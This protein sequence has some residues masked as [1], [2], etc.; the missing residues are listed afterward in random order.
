MEFTTDPSQNI[1][2]MGRESIVLEGRGILEAKLTAVRPRDE[3][4]PFRGPLQVQAG[5][6]CTGY[7]W[8]AIGTLYGGT[9]L[10]VY[11]YG[12]EEAV[13]AKITADV[14]DFD[15]RITQYRDHGD[16]DWYPAMTPNDAASTWRRVDDGDGP[17]E[18]TEEMS[19]LAME[20]DACMKAQRAIAKQ[21]ED[22]SI[23]IWDI[24][25][26]SMA[27]MRIQPQGTI[28]L[29]ITSSAKVF[30]FDFTAPLL[31]HYRTTG[32]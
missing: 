7:K 9:E 28:I 2:V 19:E 29:H 24:R 30:M 17:I 18:L 22:V 15:A 13:Q 12:I 4:P 1:Y 26:M 31:R 27:V 25:S 5:M 10:R 14:L 8:A 32:T 11:L 16:R 20:Y 23:W 3:P 6:M 21:K